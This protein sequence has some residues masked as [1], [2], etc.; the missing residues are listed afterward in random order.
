M[1][2]SRISDLPLIP[3]HLFVNFV[4]LLIPYLWMSLFRFV[5]FYY[6]L[7]NKIDPFMLSE[8]DCVEKYGSSR[9]LG[10]IL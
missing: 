9:T 1:G 2:E 4:I 8:W 3:I 10:A 6:F 7:L 5:Y